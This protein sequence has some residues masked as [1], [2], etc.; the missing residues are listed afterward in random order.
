MTRKNHWR[1]MTYLLAALFALAWMG[2]GHAQ[3]P[4][5]G[6]A[7]GPAPKTPWGEP[8]IA[9]IWSNP[10]LVPME[11]RQELGTREFFT[12]E[13]IA[14][15]EAELAEMNRAPGWREL[16]DQTGTRQG[17]GTERDVARAYNEHWLGDRPTKR[18]RRTSQV[19]DPP[20]G[21]IPAYTPEAQKRITAK[22]EYIEALLQGTVSGKPGP[23]SARRAEPS[24]DYNVDRINRSDGPEDR[25]SP[26]RCLGMELPV[27][28]QPGTWGGV[29]QMVQS[30]GAV[31]IYYDVFQGWGFSRLIRIGD[32]PHLPPHIRLQYGDAVGRWEGDTLVVDITNFSHKTNFR[33][34]RENLH[35]IE[36]YRR[37]D[38]NTLEYRVTVEDPTTW[39]RP[40]TM[41]QE[42]TINDP[43]TTQVLESGCHEGNFGM[44]GMLAG[45]RAAEKAF[46]E[47]KGPDPATE[48]H[49]TGG[50]PP[51]HFV[52]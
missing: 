13:E 39:V 12:D 3:A 35:L 20:D 32:R 22:R 8:E 51:A 38:A 17:V 10:V 36:R 1:R 29:V 47:G 14:K 5:G 52:Q 49:A 30:P 26:E 11:R 2:S 45:M 25:S 42:W 27:L 40:W 6:A 48:D 31:G 50:E 18:G 15:A 43:R 44:T 21:R 24:P 33:G 41:V 28:L 4:V 37:L 7:A 23:V 46:A 16:R 19:I 9:G 34:A